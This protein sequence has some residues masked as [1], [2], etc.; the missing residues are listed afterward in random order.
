MKRC[1]NWG[2]VM[3]IVPADKVWAPGLMLAEGKGRK[4]YLSDEELKAVLTE[5]RKHSVTMHSLITLAVG[6][7][8]RRGEFGETDLG[9]HRP[10]PLKPADFGN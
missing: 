9:R 5:A 6:T 8:M 10:R 4:R 2:R 3:R 1:L 7:G